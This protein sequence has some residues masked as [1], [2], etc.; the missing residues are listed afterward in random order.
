MWHDM[1]IDGWQHATT[2]VR[3]RRYGIE[4]S[5]IQN[6]GEAKCTIGEISIHCMSQESWI[7]PS[8]SPIHRNKIGLANSHAQHIRFTKQCITYALQW[9]D[10]LVPS[11]GMLIRNHK[12][13]AIIQSNCDVD[14]AIVGRSTVEQMWRSMACT[15]VGG[16]MQTRQQEQGGMVWKEVSYDEMGGAQ[17]IIGEISI[18][19]TSQDSGKTPLSSQ[20]HR[21]NIGHAHSNVQHIRFPNN[22]LLTIYI[23]RIGWSHHWDDKQRSYNTVRWGNRIA[24]L[25]PR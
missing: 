1:N 25:I 7:L 12:T 5:V 19:C 8:S 9:L 23:N 4:R 6:M 2:P 21:D 17:C 24:M 13:C 11:I 22:A 3:T 20:I 15:S 14:P 10:V 18:R 16:S